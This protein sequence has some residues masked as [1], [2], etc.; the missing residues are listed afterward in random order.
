[1]KVRPNRRR[2]NPSD[3]R[4]WRGLMPTPGLARHQTQWERRHALLRA[5]EAGATAASLAAWLHEPWPYVEALLGRAR[6]E[7]QMGARS[8]AELWIESGWADVWRLL[9]D[10]APLAAE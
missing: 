4:R 10:A 9:R 3:G 2:G 1:M 5:H 7:R 6:L 8:P